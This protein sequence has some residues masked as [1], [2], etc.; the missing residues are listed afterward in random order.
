MAKRIKGRDRLLDARASVTIERI[1]LRTLHVQTAIARGGTLKP[2][3][4]VAA[5]FGLDDFET[6]RLSVTK[7]GTVLS[8][9]PLQLRDVVAHVTPAVG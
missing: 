5:V 9:L 1:G 7:I 4:V 3:H 2:H 6:Q 8:P